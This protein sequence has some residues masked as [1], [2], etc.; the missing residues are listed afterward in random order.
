MDKITL[1]KE[2]AIRI[3]PGV[4]EPHIFSGDPDWHPHD[5]EYKQIVAIKKATEIVNFVLENLE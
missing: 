2:V 5:D 3:D 1:I 4:W